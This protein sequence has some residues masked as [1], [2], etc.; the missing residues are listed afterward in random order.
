MADQ[1]NPSDSF[2]WDDP[3]GKRMDTWRAYQ[4]CLREHE[5]MNAQLMRLQI[6]SEKMRDPERWQE[7]IME[8]NQKQ[9]DK[10]QELNALGLVLGKSEHEIRK[11]LLAFRFGGR[12]ETRIP[13]LMILPYEKKPYEQAEQDRMDSMYEPGAVDLKQPMFRDAVHPNADIEQPKNGFL[14]L[15]SMENHDS[16]DGTST[17]TVDA[18]AELKKTR[19]QELLVTLQKDHPNFKPQLVKWM[20]NDQGGYHHVSSTDYTALFIEDNEAETALELVVNLIKASPEKFWLTPSEIQEWAHKTIVETYVGYLREKDLFPLLPQSPEGEKAKARMTHQKFLEAVSMKQHNESEY[21]YG[22]PSDDLLYDLRVSFQKK[23]LL[24]AEKHVIEG[25]SGFF[26]RDDKLM[27]LLGEKELEALLTIEEEK[28][29]DGEE[30]ARAIWKKLSD[31]MQ[32]ELQASFPEEH[33]WFS[34]RQRETEASH[35]TNRR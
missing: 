26:G 14:L 33:T 23:E 17:S 4:V 13:G 5:D 28:N 24:D 30:S 22:E 18:D 15:I 9:V 7:R 8:L 16:V 31:Q 21:H 12:E 10:H 20:G 11:E 35:E 6:S 32:R 2:A 29:Q 1:K 19:M 25:Q 27:T 34:E 3:V